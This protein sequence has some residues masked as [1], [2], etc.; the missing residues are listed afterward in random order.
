MT[1]IIVTH[2]DNE[3]SELAFDAGQETISIGRRSAN[4][5]CIPDLS[6]SGSHA[7][8]TFEADEYWLEDLN[9]T[10]GTYVNGQPVTRQIILD[11]D[12]I[13]I[14]KIR[15]AFRSGKV[16]SPLADVDVDNLASSISDLPVT[17]DFGDGHV[18]SMDEID[19][20]SLNE[21]HQGIGQEANSRPEP[22]LP[23]AAD[24][25]PETTS[26]PPNAATQSPILELD[27]TTATSKGA[28]I[29]IKNGAKSGQ[30]LPIDK[31]VTTLGR[32][33]IQIA[34]IMRKPDGYFLMHI[35]SDDSVDR[36]TLNRDVIGDEPV[37]L[38]SGDQ[39]NVAG[40]DV[41]FML[42]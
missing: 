19:P 5:V 23:A 24:V 21:A 28:V 40:I 26:T 35:E 27:S 20:L 8:I 7:R 13:V 30:I 4:D 37:L 33:G 10:N 16:Q 15:L 6:V 39:L 3:V 31:P 38:H 32:P 25:K 9:S 17:S 34:A 1:T 36:P 18:E 12:E 41:E 42:S 22:E 14:G 29:E 11:N 2:E